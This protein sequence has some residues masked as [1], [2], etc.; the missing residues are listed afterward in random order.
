[1]K[2]WLQEIDRYASEGVNKLLVGNKS[3]LGTKRAVEF[4]EA[5][6][7][8]QKLNIPFLETSAK[9]A[10]NVEQ[11][12]LTM[13]KQIKDRIGSTVNNQS[14]SKVNLGSGQKLPTQSGCC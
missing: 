7:F 2:T 12:F 14:S 1:M 10:T 13:A 5:N 11:A 6:E 9:N 4:S 8:A 3:D